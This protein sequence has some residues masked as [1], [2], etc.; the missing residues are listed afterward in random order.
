MAR[1]LSAAGYSKACCTPHHIRGAWHLPA[2]EV[3][4]AVKELQ[5]RL[6]EADIKLTLIPGREYYLDEFLLQELDDL[7]LLPGDLLL[8]EFPDRCDPDRARDTLFQL[9]C[10]KITPL[11]AHPE[12]TSLLVPKPDKKRRVTGVLGSLFNSEFKTHNSKLATDSL[13]TYLQ[14]IGCRFQGN[15]GSFAGVYGAR[16]HDQ[17]AG[18]LKAGVYTHFGSDG[19]TPGRLEHIIVN[20]H[21]EIERLR[22]DVKI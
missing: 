8:V 11:I 22:T 5:G 17:A 4:Q 9:V 13:L 15:L 21:K 16:V 3:R 6:D 14:E 12:R 18:L 10:R 1:I 7:L 19:H 20:G 2:G